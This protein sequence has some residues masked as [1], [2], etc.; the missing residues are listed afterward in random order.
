MDIKDILLFTSGLFL[1]AFFLKFYKQLNNNNIKISKK[2]AILIVLSM[3]I[4]EIMSNFFLK[5]PYSFILSFAIIAAVSFIL[6][7]KL[8]ESLILTIVFE[9]NIII[10][11]MIIIIIVSM[12]FKSYDSIPVI[13]FQILLYQ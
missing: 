3:T 12:L 2:K 7:S 11:E 1:N 10:S 9:I 5:K 4:I 13:I 8:K 6:S